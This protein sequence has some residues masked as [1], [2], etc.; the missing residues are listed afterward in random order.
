MV[1]VSGFFEYGIAA[2]LGVVVMMSLGI[3]ALV[4]EDSYRIDEDSV[5]TDGE[6]VAPEYPLYKKAA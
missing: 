4:G 6:T 1:P 3:W 2:L 5:G